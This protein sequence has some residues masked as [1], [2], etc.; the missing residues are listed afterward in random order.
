VRLLQHALKA[1]TRAVLHALYE[2]EFRGLENV[3]STGPVILAPNHVNYLD[4]PLLLAFLR[5]P[6]YFVAASGAFTIPVWATLLRLYG[7][8]SVERG[9]TDA[10]MLKAALAV[11]GRGEALGI[12]PEGTFTQD[13]HTVPAKLGAAHLA[14]RTGA[15]IVPVTIAGAF[16]SWPRLGPLKRLLP[17]PW[18][19]TV[20]FH[21]PIRLTP[22][23]LEQH[24]RDKEFARELTQR[25]MD[26]LNRT[27]EP[28]LR[29][30]QRVDELV[31]Q[32]GPPV[33]LYELFPL[34]LCAA[35]AALL[36]GRTV[37]FT[38]PA[39]TPAALRFLAAFAGLG[40]LY[41]AY[42]AVDVLRS[43]QTVLTRALRNLSPFGFLLLYYP[44]LVRGIPL[45]AHVAR[46][47]PAAYPLWL[48]HQP[49]PFRWIVSDWLFVTY[50]AFLPY[51]LLSVRHYY[52]NDY[53]AF[54]RF[55]RGL[56]LSA[57][58]A[59]LTILYLPA[60]GSSFRL[61][62]PLE[63]LGLFAPWIAE[64][65]VSRLVMGSFPT[66]VVTVTLYCAAF[67]WQHHRRLFWMLAAPALSGVLSPAFL[68]GYPLGALAANAA[69]VALVLL[70]MRW[71]PMTAHD[72][73]PV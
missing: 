18:R 69:L 45:A 58:A 62:V 55:M 60:I 34:F 10:S 65:H 36:A 32:R 4:A 48:T 21:E 22:A 9:K 24:A 25:V 15:P 72:G 3:P 50:F 61:A 40:V 33:R 7:T 73:R 35:A 28:A 23:E 49:I 20:T 19:L 38:D 66:V 56:L 53:R 39:T 13:G 31:R 51:L 12:F 30:E 52:F 54:Q 26:A 47:H 1:L 17:R 57:Y 43:R 14:L 37:G 41:F 16:R 42:L 59:L 64:F 44:L 70:Y 71:L 29:A 68:R 8:I 46:G 11:L 5:R 2:L 27:L 67:A 63:S 6:V